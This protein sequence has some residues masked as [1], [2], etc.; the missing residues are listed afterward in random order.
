M[1]RTRASRAL[2]GRRRRRGCRRCC[3]RRRSSGRQRSGAG[4]FGAT[5]GD[6]SR[7]QRHDGAAVRA[8]RGKS[9][10]EGGLARASRSDTSL[11]RGRDRTCPES[12]SARA[13]GCGSR[14]ERSRRVRQ[15]HSGRVL[16]R[17][18]GRWGSASASCS[19]GCRAC[20]QCCETGQ[21]CEGRSVTSGSTKEP[22]SAS[23]RACSRV[24]RHASPETRRSR[25][26][27][28][29]APRGR[30]PRK[31]SDASH[32]CRG[33]A[34]DSCPRR[35][36]RPRSW[37]RRF[38]ARARR[39]RARA[40]RFRARTRRIRSRARIRRIPRCLRSFSRTSVPFRV[41]RLGSSRLALRNRRALAS[42]PSRVFSVGRV[43]VPHGT[44]LRARR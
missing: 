23:S 13:A 42:S 20:G 39:I 19:E 10:N 3:E 21:F 14:R 38:R 43:G 40:R 30:A 35:S 5:R 36:Q 33:G 34:C 12:E 7:C 27:A 26:C 15:F 29:F 44:D 17:G 31:R 11:A 25:S 4:R 6:S 28:S 9:C 2:G 22:S 18:C 24:A 37:S 32:E 8:G 41:A 16:L 1:V